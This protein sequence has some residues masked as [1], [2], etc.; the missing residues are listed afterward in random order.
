ME[1]EN[2]EQAMDCFKKVLDVDPH[3]IIILNEISS[4]YLY[5]EEYDL[6]FNCL[7]D[8]LKKDEENLEVLLNLS[9]L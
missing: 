8:I 5:L 6:A 4:C 2:Y 9:L 3:N 7:N 1:L